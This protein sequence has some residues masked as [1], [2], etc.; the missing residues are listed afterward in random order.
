MSQQLIY[1]SSFFVAAATAL[2]EITMSRRSN[3][4]QP[5]AQ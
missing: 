3:G 5:M 4:G 1:L 2:P